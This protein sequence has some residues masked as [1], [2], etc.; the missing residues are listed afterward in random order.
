MVNVVVKGDEVAVVF[1]DQEADKDAC[2]IQAD[3]DLELC[4]GLEVNVVALPD[5]EAQELLVPFDD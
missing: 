1:N 4:E 5:C 3:H 2:E